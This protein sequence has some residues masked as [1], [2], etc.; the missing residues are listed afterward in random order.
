MSTEIKKKVQEQFGQNAEAY[1]TSIVHGRGAS[2]GRIVELAQPRAMDRALDV[3]TAAGHTAMALAPHVRTVVGF[4]LTAAMFVPARRLAGERGLQN[5]TWLNGDVECM[6]LAT[7]S[8]D[9]VVCRISL[10]HW[11]DAAQGIR[12]MARV[13]AHG[14]RVMLVDNVAPPDRRLAE[15]VNHYEQVRDPSHNWC[16][17]LD[18][19]QAMFRQSGLTI[20]TTEVLDKPTGFDDWVQRMSV[21]APTIADL[22]QMLRTPEAA[23]T[24]RPDTLDGVLRFHLSEAIVAAVKP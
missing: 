19:L 24:I 16:Y 9:I 6:P 3:A 10:H 14:G 13:T 7:E 15:F 17:A 12:E 22:K 11:P 4:D 20:E 1:A 21:P 8:F 18:A 23:A 2:L 5:I